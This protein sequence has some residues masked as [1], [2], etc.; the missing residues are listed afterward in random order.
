MILIYLY[1]HSYFIV[2]VNFKHF[3]LLLIFIYIVNYSLVIVC[4]I[5][6]VYLYS[7][8]KATVLAE[9]LPRNI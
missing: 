4:N 7:V 9:I 5:V 2:M 3:P 1:N 6:N 8:N